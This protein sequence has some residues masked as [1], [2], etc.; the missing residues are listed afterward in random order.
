MLSSPYKS[1]YSV[2]TGYVPDPPSYRYCIGYLRAKAGASQGDSRAAPAQLKVECERE[3]RTQAESTLGHLI[4]YSW[5][6]EEAAKRHVAVS[7]A[8]I[9]G[10]I[11]KRGVKASILN[12]LGVQP[13]DQEFVVGAE[14]LTRKLFSTLP[15]YR[16][17]RRNE[18]PSI[19]AADEIDNEDVQFYAAIKQR[20]IARTHCDP[21][22]IVPGC[23]E[24][25]SEGLQ[26]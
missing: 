6:Y 23:S 17:M 20:W 25:S 4:R 10:E 11:A 2:P 9:Q 24:Y 16:R 19:K 1:G 12:A 14:L 21:E 8:E 5:I 18:D 15:A 26:P 22:F 13:S 3:H 7:A